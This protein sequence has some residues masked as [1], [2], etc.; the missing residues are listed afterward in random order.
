MDIESTPQAGDSCQSKVLFDDTAYSRLKR[1]AAVYMLDEKPGHTLCPTA[2]V[3]EVYLRHGGHKNSGQVCRRGFY[4]AAA[5]SMRQILVD[6][7]RAKNA[8]KRGAGIAAITFDEQIHSNPAQNVDVLA[9]DQALEKLAHRDQN[10][11]RIVEMRYFSGMT[12]EEIAGELQV[13]L[14]TVKRKWTAARA[15]L[16]RELCSAG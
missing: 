2:L 4:A 11:V 15:W 5:R 7:A 3:K 12:L 10:K 8:L 16:F 1:M 14:A 9:L 6:H 13:S